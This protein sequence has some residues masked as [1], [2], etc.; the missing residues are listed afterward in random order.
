MDGLLLIILLH[1]L[2]IVLAIAFAA[3]MLSFYKSELE[4]V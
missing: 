1:A 2:L 3:D 4:A